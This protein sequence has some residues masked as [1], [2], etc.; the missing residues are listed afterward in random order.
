MKNPFRRK[1][2]DPERRVCEKADRRTWVD[3]RIKLH[4]E[5]ERKWSENESSQ[6][7]EVLLWRDGGW[8]AAAWGR[9]SVDEAFDFMKEIAGPP[10]H[11]TG[12]PAVLLGHQLLA[13]QGTGGTYEEPPGE[14]IADRNRPKR[15]PL[16]MNQHERLQ[17]GDR[18]P[19]GPGEGLH[20]RDANGGGPPRRL[21]AKAPP[22][23]HRDVPGRPHH[24]HPQTHG[25][26]DGRRRACRNPVGR[27]ADGKT[28]QNRRTSWQI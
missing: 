6:V 17:H 26:G 13:R 12:R 18:G 27:S 19:G 16:P 8:Q 23:R 1:Q 20:E 11:Q 15:H 22:G 10:A 14:D 2:T 7:W 24:H 3:P 4:L 28:T 9:H 25:D 5:G 21:D